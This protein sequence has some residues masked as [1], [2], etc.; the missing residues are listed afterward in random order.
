MRKAIINFGI[1]AQL[2][3]GKVLNKVKHFLRDEKSAREQVNEGWMIYAGITIGIIILAL[4]LPFLRDTFTD[5]MTY[6]DDGV[7]GNNT[8]PNGWGN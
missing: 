6:F 3:K 7:N 5:I 4:A 2:K 8:N 1:Q